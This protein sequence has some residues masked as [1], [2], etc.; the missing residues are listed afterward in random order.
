MKRTKERPSVAGLILLVAGM[1]LLS[2]ILLSL[3]SAGNVTPQ[4]GKWLLFLGCVAAASLAGGAAL[5]GR[6]RK[7]K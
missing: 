4:G 5:S 6:K 2:I 7:R 3:T 1:L